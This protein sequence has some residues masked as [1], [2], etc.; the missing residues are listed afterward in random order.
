MTAVRD[1]DSGHAERIRASGV[2]DSNESRQYCEGPVW[3]RPLM[4]CTL[5]TPAI[6]IPKLALSVP[7]PKEFTARFLSHHH[8]HDEELAQCPVVHFA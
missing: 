4:L 5:L 2:G 6:Y 1:E 3:D 7:P 8:R